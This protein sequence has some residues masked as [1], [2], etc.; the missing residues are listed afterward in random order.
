MF[1]PHWAEATSLSSANTARVSTV[2]CRNKT[3]RGHSTVGDVVVMDASNSTK[4]LP[5]RGAQRLHIVDQVLGHRGWAGPCVDA[6]KDSPPQPYW[7][8]HGQSRPVKIKVFL[9]SLLLFPSDVGKACVFRQ[10]LGTTFLC[11]VHAS[12]RKQLIIRRL[13]NKGLPCLASW[14]G[15]A[16]LKPILTQAFPWWWCPCPAHSKRSQQDFW[17]THPYIKHK[18]SLQFN[19]A[20]SGPANTKVS[21]A[22]SWATR[23]ATRRLWHSSSFWSSSDKLQPTYRKDKTQ[24]GWARKDP[25][26]KCICEHK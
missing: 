11:R 6:T 3:T 20:A 26:D 8:N 18:Y 24:N 7:C 2:V 5:P 25:C 12:V 4:N 22:F 14:W 16:P 23:V 10:I 15:I 19:I 9:S 1:S 13:A 21:T 17:S